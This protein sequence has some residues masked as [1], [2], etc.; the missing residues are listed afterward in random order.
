MLRESLGGQCPVW[1]HPS[2]RWRLTRTR[3]GLHRGWFLTGN[4]APPPAKPRD[5]NWP[6]ECDFLA[7]AIA[8]EISSFAG[9]KVGPVLFYW[10]TS[11]A[12]RS[13]SNFHSAWDRLGSCFARQNITELHA[14]TETRWSVT[15]QYEIWRYFCFRIASV[16]FFEIFQLVSPNLLD[17]SLGSSTIKDN[18]FH[19]RWITMIPH[20]LNFSLHRHL[21]KIV[22]FHIHQLDRFRVLKRGRVS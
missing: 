7:H 12:N 22:E 4:H 19:K 3:N 10:Q 20:D 16:R 21:L 8:G 15:R 6:R 2:G 11:L 14:F 17:A 1:R 13:C 9:A 5:E 18:K